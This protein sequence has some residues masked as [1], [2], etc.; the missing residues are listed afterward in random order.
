MAALSS[1]S[2][3]ESAP[4]EGGVTQLPCNPMY[5]RLQAMCQGCNPM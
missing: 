5:Q 1:A 3:A 2:G 4:Q